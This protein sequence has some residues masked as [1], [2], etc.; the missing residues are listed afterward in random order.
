MWQDDLILLE[1]LST[2]TPE[3]TFESKTPGGKL[4]K[5]EGKHLGKTLNDQVRQN[6]NKLDN[7]DC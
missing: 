5:V 3:K 1:T 2:E 6:I 4:L 7:D